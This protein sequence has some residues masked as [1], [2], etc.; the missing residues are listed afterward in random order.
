MGSSTLRNEP[1]ALTVSIRDEELV[2]ELV[3][4]NDL[5]AAERTAIYLLIANVAAATPA[6]NCAPTP[7]GIRAL[8]AFPRALLQS[9]QQ[10]Q[11]TC[12]YSR[13]L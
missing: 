12:R 6:L 13:L 1:K 3:D 5:S 10:K 7:S 8:R 11:S 9:H 4:G 2:L